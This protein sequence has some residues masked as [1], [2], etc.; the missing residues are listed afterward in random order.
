MFDAFGDGLELQ[1]VGELHDGAHETA[2]LVVAGDVVD[3][4]LV[5]LQDVDREL[6]EGGE[7]RVTG[8]EVVDRDAHA[9]A[10]ERVERR[11][12]AT[13]LAGE[14][15]L[16]DLEGERGRVEPGLVERVGDVFAEARVG[17]LES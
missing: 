1:R 2:A 9:G 10:A 16:G 13:G 5:D 7:R 15:R 14:H 11:D 6:G 12:D 3:E 17:E 8:A 4:L